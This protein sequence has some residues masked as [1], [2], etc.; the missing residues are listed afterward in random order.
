MSSEVGGMRSSADVTKLLRLKATPLDDILTTAVGLIDNKEK[1]YLPNKTNFL[2]ELFCDR[3]N[4]NNFFKGWKYEV[5]VWRLLLRL[6]QSLGDS[7]KA[8]SK[9][10]KKIKLIQLAIDVLNKSTEQKNLD[11]AKQI[12]DFLEAA[13]LRNYITIDEYQSVLLLESYSS[14]LL[15]CM[16]TNSLSTAEIDHWTSLV[17]K[18]FQTP[19]VLN[20]GV[21]SKKNTAK[22]C[23]LT[24]PS[25]LSAIVLLKRYE[26]AGETLRI[27][28]SIISNALL[29]ETSV[30]S[31]VPNTVLFLKS[32]KKSISLEDLRCFFAIVIRKLSSERIKTCEELFIAIVSNTDIPDIS[33]NLLQFL[34]NTNKSLSSDFYRS[35]Y[36]SEIKGCASDKL[37]WNLL[38]CLISLDVDLALDVARDTLENIPETIRKDTAMSLGKALTDAFIRARDFSLFIKT[39]LISAVERN[40]LFRNSEFIDY[41]SSKVNNL[42]LKEI[43]EILESMQGNERAVSLYAGLI[44]GL[45]YCSDEKIE[46]AKSKLLSVHLLKNEYVEL[47]EVRFYIMCIFGNEACEFFRHSIVQNAQSNLKNKYYYYCAFRMIEAT[48][49][50]KNVKLNAFETGYINFLESCTSDQLLPLLEN[51]LK[52]WPVILNMFF[53]DLGLNKFIDILVRDTNLTMML[54]ILSK[55]SD[56]LFEQARLMTKLVDSISKK[57]D[58]KDQLGLTLALLQLI[59]E[60]YLDKHIRI[61]VTNDLTSNS[62]IFKNDDLANLAFKCLFKLLA[63][64]TGKAKIEMNINNMFNFVQMAAEYSKVMAT[65]LI[66]LIWEKNLN[67]HLKF[68]IVKSLLQYIDTFDMVLISTQPSEFNVTSKIINQLSKLDK[69]DVLTVEIKKLRTNFLNLVSNALSECSSNIDASVLNTIDWLLDVC[70]NVISSEEDNSHQIVKVL[71]TLG[72]SLKLDAESDIVNSIKCRMFLVFTQV[73][74]T[75]NKS[76]RFLVALYL[77]LAKSVGVESSLDNALNN[78]LQKLSVQPEMLQQLFVDTIESINDPDNAFIE[79]LI[80]V[81]VL[82]IQNLKTDEKK[83]AEKLVTKWL[84]TLLSNFDLLIKMDADY[85]I[86]MLDSLRTYLTSK[87]WIFG[88]YEI[89]NILAFVSRV[90]SNMSRIETNDS[91][92]LISLYTKLTQVVSNII[93][94]H[95]FRLTSRHHITVATFINLLLPLSLNSPYSVKHISFSTDAAHTYTRLL[96]NLCEPSNVNIKDVANSSLTSS[97]SIV[98]KLLRKHL[99]LLLASYIST[100]IKYNFEANVTSELLRGFYLIFDV[101]SRSELHLVNVLLDTPGRSYY[102]TLLSSYKDHGKWKDD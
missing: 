41:I 29:S 43:P 7:P 35:I 60:K 83:D 14:F 63:R 77:L 62:Y 57:L 87:P 85:W 34:L 71:K 102:R 70:N 93:L 49:L 24:L 65:D 78:Y 81:C 61:K 101:L 22:F 23:Q 42:S 47:W 18:I 90:S 86:F 73:Y 5:R 96:S 52:R 99:P 39:Y 55:S 51:T 89:E 48:P 21:F 1:V 92:S 64:P 97:A 68:D 66:I 50:E 94:Y 46:N 32:D 15:S 11:L 27:F 95:R 40:Q 76:S 100:L 59:P 2:I 91:S 36:D 10:I 45:V 88:Q 17:D 3:L 69:D 19:I 16:D 20:G 54:K 80:K 44:K 9:I 33:L 25:L 72:S 98:R 84:S 30:Q 74:P 31:L 79:Q 82:I 4:D 6:W 58:E 56:V 67:D 37:N 8:R 53:S 38:Q 26:K 28:E 13:V 75:S 12:F